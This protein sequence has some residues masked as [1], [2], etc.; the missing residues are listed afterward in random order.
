MNE[1]G[2][3]ET[4]CVVEKCTPCKKVGKLGPLLESITKNISTL[5]FITCTRKHRVV[6][7]QRF[8]TLI[9]N[10]LHTRNASK[11]KN[12]FKRTKINLHT[13]RLPFFWN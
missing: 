10:P 3:A 8:A 6:L 11:T 12:Q 5:S 13:F 4:K 9:L 2:A 7:L 1:N